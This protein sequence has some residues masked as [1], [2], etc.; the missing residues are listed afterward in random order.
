MIEVPAHLSHGT[1]WVYRRYGCRC[2]TCRTFQ[3]ERNRQRRR[4]ERAKAKELWAEG[5]KSR[6][7]F[8]DEIAVERAKHGD[9]VVLTVAERVVV[10]AQLTRAGLVGSEIARRLGVSRRTV[11]R[12]RTRL[13]REP[14]QEAA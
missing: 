6:S 1:D 4:E 13:R 14:L 5:R 2:E 12:Y 8:I 3:R 11:Q 7:P 9:R 10:A